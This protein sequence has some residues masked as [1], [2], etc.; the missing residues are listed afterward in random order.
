MSGCAILEAVLIQGGR[1]DFT[2]PAPRLFAPKALVAEVAAH[3]PEV[4]EV[5]RRAAI[6][7][8]EVGRFIRDGGVPP[9]LTLPDHPQGPCVSC[10]AD[11]DGNRYRCPVCVLAVNLA[12]EGRP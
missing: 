10:G 2:A 6:F 11:L 3:G 4:R 9:L 5:L 1:V 7:R 12:V 8:A